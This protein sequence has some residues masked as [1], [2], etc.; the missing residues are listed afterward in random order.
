MRLSIQRIKRLNIL[1]YFW[2]IPRLFREKLQRLSIHFILISSL[3]LQ[4]RTEPRQISVESNQRNDLGTIHPF[5]TRVYSLYNFSRDWIFQFDLTKS[6]VYGLV[7]DNLTGRLPCDSW[8]RGWL[9]SMYNTH[10]LRASYTKVWK[11]KGTMNLR[12]ILLRIEQAMKNLVQK[13]N[14][15]K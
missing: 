8:D 10:L 2:L 5:K 7:P 14:N 1:W 6:S 15:C 9:L 3:A 12:E 11:I 13:M 4:C